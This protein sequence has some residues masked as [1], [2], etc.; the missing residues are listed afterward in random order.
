M[1]GIV[2]AG[3]GV[4][5]LVVPPLANLLI[6]NY[7]WRTSY[8]IL[9]IVVIVVVIACSQFLKRD[10]T[11]T[12]QLPHGE[13]EVNETEL[14]IDVVPFSLKQAMGTRQFW[15]VVL[16][17]FCSGFCLYAIQ[18][19]L[20]PHVT[21]MGISASSA[22]TILAAVGGASIV[23]RAV[24]GS[25]GDRIGNRRAYLLGYCLIAAAL[26]WLIASRELW[27]FYLFAVIFGLAY[28]NCDTQ[29]SPLVAALFGLTS[30]GLIFGV[31]AFGY[32]MGAALGPFIA[33]YVYDTTGNYQMAFILCVIIGVVGIILSALLRPPRK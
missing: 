28:G 15:M 27:N 1:T 18:V 20:A 11:Q 33:G 2:A 22:A 29:Q 14:N 8:M 24:L 10:P 21:D 19:H 7:Q 4:G 30:H 3:I 16:M 25:I 13:N 26:L 9:G 6:A 5:A 31:V 32:A 12:G 23:G 17:L